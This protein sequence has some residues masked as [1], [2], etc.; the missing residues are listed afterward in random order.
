[1]EKYCVA[2]SGEE[3][4]GLEQMVSTG[5]AAARRLI[6]ARILLL[7]DAHS[8]SRSSRRNAR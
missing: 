1:M 7:A 8:R 3:R 5:Q 2:L 6:H 4:Q